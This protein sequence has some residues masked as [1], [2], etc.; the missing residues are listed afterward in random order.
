MTPMLTWIVLP[1]GLTAIVLLLLACFYP[2]VD[3]VITVKKT[4][5]DLEAERRKEWDRRKV[6]PLQAKR[7]SSQREG[8]AA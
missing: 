4:Q 7:R 2:K 6:V 3:F 1:V 8:D 5:A